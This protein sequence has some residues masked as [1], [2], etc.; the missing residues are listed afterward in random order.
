MLFVSVAIIAGRAN[1]PLYGERCKSSLD[2]SI[3]IHYIINMKTQIPSV[4]KLP[5]KSSS[6]GRF[7]YYFKFNN[8]IGI[9]VLK[10]SIKNLNSVGINK[11]AKELTALQM[12]QPL[13]YTPKV[14]GF[15]VI[16]YDNI[17]KLGI[18]ME[19]INGKTFSDYHEQNF[20]DMQFDQWDIERVM[21]PKLE[22]CGID[23]GDWHNENI[24][25]RRGTNLQTMSEMKK[26]LNKFV[27]IDFS[28]EFCNV[29]GSNL[30][31]FETKCKI[32]SKAIRKFLRTIGVK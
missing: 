31:E 3:G 4:I 25:V 22:K 8:K 12:C 14:Y 7:A 19:H 1:Y 17:K 10:K 26:N 11:A 32:N 29:V 28:P 24:I 27:R 2:I 21:S 30:N 9:K 23:V 16:Q 5:K 15:T 6:H 13:G 18:V 20:S